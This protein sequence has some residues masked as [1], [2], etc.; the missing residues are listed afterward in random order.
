M[1]KILKCNG[2]DLHLAY[3]SGAVFC[4]S[5]TTRC[6]RK[7]VNHMLKI[8]VKYEFWAKTESQDLVCG[9]IT[10][11]F[12]NFRVGVGNEKLLFPIDCVICNTLIYLVQSLITGIHER[13]LISWLFLYI[14][15]L[16]FQL[17]R[18]YAWVAEV[19]MNTMVHLD[20]LKTANSSFWPLPPPNLQVLSILP[21]W[22]GSAHDFLSFIFLW[23]RQRP[24]AY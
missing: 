8:S 16:L 21:A 1:K 22:T 5:Q 24:V 12:N 18:Q 20:S 23:E 2:L 14:F 13:V 6:A 3:F 9:H 15:L 4:F 10:R 19:E 7:Y 11:L 17:H